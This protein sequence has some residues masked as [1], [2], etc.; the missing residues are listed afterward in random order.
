VH[1]S[2]EKLKFYSFTILE[3]YGLLRLEMRKTAR[4][5]L[6]VFDKYIFID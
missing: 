3:K 1:L 2:R 4:E 5:D 6:A